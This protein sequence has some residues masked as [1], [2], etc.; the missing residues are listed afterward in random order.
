MILKNYLVVGLICAFLPGSLGS[1]DSL[2][3]QGSLEAI[4]RGLLERD[5]GSCEAQ[6]FVLF[7]YKICFVS[8]DCMDTTTRGTTRRTTTQPEVVCES[9]VSDYIGDGMCD[10]DNNNEACDFDG[11]DC[12]LETGKD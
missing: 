7:G 4:V 3:A 5:E 1:L 10:D 12:C 8:A 11:G 2:G 6:C 9:D